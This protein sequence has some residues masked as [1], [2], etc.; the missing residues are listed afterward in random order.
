MSMMNVFGVLGTLLSAAE[1]ALGAKARVRVEQ[2][3]LP[4]YVAVSST[5]ST[6]GHRHKALT[7]AQRCAQSRGR[8][9]GAWTAQAMPAGPRLRWGVSSRG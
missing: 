2:D 7:A 4:V 5:G 6:C 8:R 1:D 9:G 3:L